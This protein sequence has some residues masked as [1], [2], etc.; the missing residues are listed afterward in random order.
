MGPFQFLFLGGPPP[1]E[2]GVPFGHP[3][4]GYTIF[5]LFS[6]FISGMSAIWQLFAF[7]Y[8]LRFF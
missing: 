1:F 3:D 4:A 6:F 7:L 5:F 8:S 2:P